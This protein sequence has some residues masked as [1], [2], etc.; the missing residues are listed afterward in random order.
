MRRYAAA[1]SASLLIVLIGVS[2]LVFSLEQA[3]PGDPAVVILTRTLGQP[4]TA[5]QVQEERHRL[6]LD[7]PLPA[8]YVTW[9]AQAVRGNLGDSWQ[10]GAGVAASLGRH[11]PYT[12]ELAAAAAALALLTGVPLGV[13][14][15]WRRNSATDQVLRAVSLT[16]AS[17]PSYFVAYLLIALFG[18]VLSVLPVFGA[19]SPDHL[20]LPAVT[21]A[22]APA[23]TIVRLTRS[24]VL[25]VL[26]EDYV[27]TAWAKGL[28]PRAV[29]FRHALRCSLNPVITVF[30]LVSAHLLAGSVIVE[31][32]FS[33][34]GLGTELLDAIHSR[35][36]PIIQGCL[37]F[38]AAVYVTVNFLCD[39]AYAWLDPRIRLWRP[40]PD[41]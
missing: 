4:P 6:G 8:Q 7:R 10:T 3:T 33:W 22:L 25:E 23:A 36:F 14:A 21:L 2:I 19:G 35:D 32:I 37:L 28:S 26:A 16:G 5:Q 9:L 12:A 15:A 34:P 20:I 39:L 24:A 29:L 18:V 31:S 30:A 1:R 13:L 11:I 27:R 41:R 40:E 38:I 17:L